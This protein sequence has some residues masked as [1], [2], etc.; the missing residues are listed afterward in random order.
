MIQFILNE[1]L[2]RYNGNSGIT[3]LKFIRDVENLKGTKAGCKEGDCG[4]CTVLSG[5]LTDDG[6]VEYQ[7]ITSCLTP[8]ANVQ[9]KHIVTV[10]GQ[11]LEGELN[12]AQQAIKDNFATQCGFCTPGLLF[13]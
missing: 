5:S 8:L 1:K 2:I 13:H 11:N 9:G 4:A 6:H 7:S 12:V 3:L 10:E